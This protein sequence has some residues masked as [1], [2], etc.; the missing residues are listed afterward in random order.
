M[1]AVSTVVAFLL[2]AGVLVF[3]VFGIPVVVIWV[4]LI[5]V[6][7]ETRAAKAE[8]IVSTTLMDGENVVAKTIQKRVFA[9][10]N[11]R[12]VV[13]ITNSRILIIRRGLLGGFK[14]SDIQWK[15][16]KDVQIEQNILED[17]CG[18]NLAFRHLNGGVAP[19]IVN[20]LGSDVASAMYTR[21]Q[22][23]EQQWEEK[24]RV[25]AMEEVRAAA[26]GVVVHNAPAASQAAPAGNRLLSEI[27]EA[28]KLLDG[29]VI[30][31]AEFQEMKSKI[32][33]S[34]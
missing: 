32:L 33:A 18:S 7:A 16:L 17:F 34:G 21:A 2:V 3:S 23:E 1:K 20:G 24:R 13:A 30:S 25:R 22:S 15:D 31:D 28:K 10:F 14:M 26:G 5:V 9:L 11:R 27:Q 19:M 12:A 8:K 4:A 6:G 29:G